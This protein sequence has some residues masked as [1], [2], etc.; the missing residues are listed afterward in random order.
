VGT[1]ENTTIG[2]R[3]GTAPK[4]SAEI[5]GRAGCGGGA[6]AGFSKAALIGAGG[7]SFPRSTFS[8]AFNLSRMA[9]INK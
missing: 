5:F 7:A 3:C 9:G 1:F 6:I 4:R 8:L 2:V